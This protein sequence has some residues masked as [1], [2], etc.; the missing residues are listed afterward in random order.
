MEEIPGL[1][2]EGWRAGILKG[3]ADTLGTAPASA[4]GWSSGKNSSRP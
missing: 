1:R 2:D 4:G 3:D